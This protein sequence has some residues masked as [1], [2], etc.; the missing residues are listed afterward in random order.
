MVKNNL[1]GPRLQAIRLL[2]SVGEKC[3]LADRDRWQV[4]ECAGRGSR[5]GRFQR[6]SR[7]KAPGYLEV[8]DWSPDS[9]KLLLIF[10]P[11]ITWQY[12]KG[13]LLEFDLVAAKEDKARVPE[14]PSLPRNPA[15]RPPRDWSKP[16]STA[17]DSLMTSLR[18]ETRD[19]LLMRDNHRT[20]GIATT[21]YHHPQQPA[22]ISIPRIL[23]WVC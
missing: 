8:N 3:P 11:A 1:L 23:S 14:E 20:A 15:S 6:E 19:P 5:C 18:W 21:L 13:D 22:R 10:R 16:S 9:R 17:L 2:H 7:P 12:G 4:A